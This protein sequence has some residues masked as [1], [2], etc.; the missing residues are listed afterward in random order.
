M[1]QHRYLESQPNR[2]VVCGQLL[3]RAL[4]K[5]L[6]SRLLI[7][8]EGV[9]QVLLPQLMATRARYIWSRTSEVQRRGYFFAGVGYRAGAFLDTNLS[10]LV[11]LLLRAESAIDDSNVPELVDAIAQFAELVLRVAPFRPQRPMPDRWKEALGA[12][13]E[14]HA[15]STVMD[16]LGN[17]GV[18]F[19]H[20]TISYRL[21]WAMEAVRVHATA[22]GIPGSDELTGMAA[23]AAESGSADRSVI[24]LIRSGLRSRE[25]AVQAATQTGASFEDRNG[26]EV[27]LTSEEVQS[28]EKNVNWPTTRTHYIWE[29]FYQREQRR[30]NTIWVRESSTLEVEWFNESPP[31]GKYVVLE[32]NPS[33]DGTIVMSPDRR[34]LGI[35]KAPLHR[36]LS[37]I[38][39]ARIGED[40]NLITVEFFGPQ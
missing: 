34:E 2:Y 33:A 3:S 20:D 31:S 25:A 14:G 16:I 6:F 37:Q 30:R 29:Q 8:R 24:T 10:N 26:L 9:E 35:V 23:M 12:W 4:D 21:Q 13:V 27:W 5:S 15:G 39:G 38:V 40:A 1:H 19:L 28:Q 11:T 7:H 36:P 18:D 17:D 22:V 32:G